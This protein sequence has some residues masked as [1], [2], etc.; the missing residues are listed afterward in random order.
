MSIK[1]AGTMENLAWRSLRRLP[2][3]QPATDTN[4]LD[5]SV[6][7][8][9]SLE[10]E[11]RVLGVYTDPGSPHEPVIV[12]DLGLHF[13]VEQGWDFVRYRAIASVAIPDDKAAAEHLT[14]RMKDGTIKK[15]PV[16]GGDGKFRDAF[17]FMHF[18]DR[19]A[20]LSRAG[21]AGEH[22]RSGG[23]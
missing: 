23:K 11:E 8:S 5:S 14:V 4:W 15:V 10:N 19:T 22:A 20:R 9:F 1:Q 13:P 16:R 17:I 6:A 12:T 3:Y 21:R 2:R 7:P 18:L